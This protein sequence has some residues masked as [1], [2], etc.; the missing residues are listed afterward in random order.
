MSE[1]PVQIDTD[2]GAAPA[3]RRVG[4]AWLDLTIAATAIAI[5]L[6]SLAVAWNNTRIQQ[7][8]LTAASWPMVQMMHGNADRDGN[9]RVVTFWLRNSGV[10]PARIESV[11][12]TWKGRPVTSQTAFLQE[13][14]GAQLTPQGRFGHN[15]TVNTVS[16]GVLI[17]GQEAPFLML[18]YAPDID[19]VWSRLD[20]ARQDVKLDICY[21]SV[22]DECWR[23]DG[24]MLH[25]PRVK[26]CPKDTPGFAQ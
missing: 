4:H 10:G 18:P 7:K 15:L 25:P 6:I 9:M 24:R 3:A 14:C 17:A 11:R 2:G 22:F 12:M 5:S 26:S 23:T 8:M 21:C 20:E 16:P 19:A 1:P 13:C